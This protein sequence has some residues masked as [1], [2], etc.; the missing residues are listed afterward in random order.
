MGFKESIKNGCL[1]GFIP[2]NL[3]IEGK[4]EFNVFPFNVMFMNFGTK[5]GARISGEAIY[6]PDLTSYVRE[7]GKCTMKYHNAYGG[8][9]WLLI[10]YDET[11]KSYFGEKFVNDESVG[12]A[13]GPQW[14]KFF[15]HFTM[16][17]LADG[18][19]CKFNPVQ[20]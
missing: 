19:M 6:D 2:H 7:N 10:A 4:P 12:I 14:D 15:I 1:Y 9:C 13:E 20:I 18:E 3:E 11:N 16:L 5:D 8:N 17:G